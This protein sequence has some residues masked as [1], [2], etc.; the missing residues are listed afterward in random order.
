MLVT[1]LSKQKKNSFKRTHIPNSIPSV[2][3][4]ASLA[5]SFAAFLSS[6]SAQDLLYR[7]AAASGCWA[8]CCCCSCTRPP[9]CH[10]SSDYGTDKRGNDTTAGV[11]SRSHALLPIINNNNNN[12]YDA[13]EENTTD[14]ALRPSTTNVANATTLRPETQEL[15]ASKTD[16][17][18]V[19]AMLEQG[20]CW[21]AH[22]GKSAVAMETAITPSSLPRQQLSYTKQKSRTLFTTPKPD[23]FCE[24]RTSR[25]STPPR[26]TRPARGS[27]YLEVSTSKATPRPPA[28]AAAG[29]EAARGVRRI[30][31]TNQN[32]LHVIICML[33]S[34]L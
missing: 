26:P 27:C 34:G 8:L 14:T 12:P 28:L 15:N 18:Q 3:Y 20:E 16:G 10:S 5:S 1:K 13:S 30:E 25:L 2:L 29:R 22:H 6:L 9:C 17:V 11:D 21:E 33:P 23:Q 31:Q 19:I 32:Y 4:F 24:P 7:R